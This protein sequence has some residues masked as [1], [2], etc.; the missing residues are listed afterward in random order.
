MSV[1]TYSKKSA[2]LPQATSTNHSS[3]VTFILSLE[4]RAFVTRNTEQVNSG[5]NSLGLYSWGFQFSRFGHWLLWD[6][7]WFIHHVLASSIII[8][9]NIPLPAHSEFILSRVWVTVDGAWIGEWIYWPLTH[10]SEVQVLTAPP[11]ISTVHKLS[12]HPLSP[13]PACF[14]F[15]RRSLTAA[16]DM[17]ILQLHALRSSLHS[18]PC[19]TA[20]QLTSSVALLRICCL[21]TGTCLP[22]RCPE[23]VT[24]LQSHRLAT[25][26]YVTL[27]TF[28]TIFPCYPTLCNLYSCNSIVK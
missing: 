7:Y 23:T 16:S 11:L 19:R 6:F 4:G 18:L 26:I 9:S 2:P 8:P 13:F 22:S 5:G 21:A 24:I 14:V 12:Q 10:A 27:F 20:T 1:N 15:T 17:E 28:M 3:G 25:G